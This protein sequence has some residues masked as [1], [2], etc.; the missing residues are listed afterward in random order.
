[1]YLD[2]HR[3]DSLETNGTLTYSLHIDEAHNT[4]EWNLFFVVE[5]INETLD[6][7][8][9]IRLYKKRPSGEIDL[10]IHCNELGIDTCLINSGYI[11]QNDTIY[12]D[13]KCT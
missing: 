3:I 12:I 2:Q 9:E 10:E 5:P 11:Q 8:K 1:M 7:P 4:S 6:I 13:V